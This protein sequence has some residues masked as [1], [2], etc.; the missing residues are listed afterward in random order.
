MPILSYILH[1]FVYNVTRSI[2]G[3]FHLHSKRKTVD[4]NDLPLIEGAY[5]L[6]DASY[7]DH[8]ERAGDTDTVSVSTV[9]RMEDEIIDRITY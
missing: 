4:P 9:W 7:A 1:R 3:N 6:H 5:F 8:L 2:D